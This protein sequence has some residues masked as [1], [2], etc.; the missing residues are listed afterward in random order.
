MDKIYILGIIFV[1]HP[2][3]ILSVLHIFATS[4]LLLWYVAF[5]KS[6]DERL[7]IVFLLRN[8]IIH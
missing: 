3:L 2:I 8:V 7:R 5:W 6:Y 4:R 1:S